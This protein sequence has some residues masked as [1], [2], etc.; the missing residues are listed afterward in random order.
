MCASAFMPGIAIDGER[1]AI[2]VMEHIT[3]IVCLHHWHFL[4][5]TLSDT[6]IPICEL[7]PHSAREEER[8]RELEHDTQFNV[9]LH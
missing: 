1:A 5:D 4:S 2:M 7:R 6:L 9:G 3:M 8:R